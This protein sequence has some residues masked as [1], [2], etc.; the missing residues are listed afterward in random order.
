[1]PPPMTGSVAGCLLGGV[2][3]HNASPLR[4]RNGSTLLFHI[5]DGGVK[6]NGSSFLHHSESPGG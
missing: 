3:A 2:Q 5:G 4:A 6:E 1:M